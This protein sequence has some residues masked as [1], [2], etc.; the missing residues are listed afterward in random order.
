MTRIKEER[1][2]RRHD[3]IQIVC[4]RRKDKKQRRKELWNL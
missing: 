1:E 2:T 3:G 4:E